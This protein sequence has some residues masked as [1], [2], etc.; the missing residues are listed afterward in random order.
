MKAASG[1]LRHT[2]DAQL[3]LSWDA[4][5]TL[6]ISTRPLSM[7]ST[8]HAQI[9]WDMSSL[10]DCASFLSDRLPCVEGCFHVSRTFVQCKG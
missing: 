3:M 4:Q 10:I 1:C 7:C 5:G 6:L 2:V 9:L 8:Q